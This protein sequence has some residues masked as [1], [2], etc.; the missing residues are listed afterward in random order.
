MNGE[1]SEVSKGPHSPCGHRN[2]PKARFCDVCGVKLPRHCPR[3]RA[4]NRGEANFCNNCGTGLRDSQRTPATPATA[5]FSAS[6]DSS[7]TPEPGS[8]PATLETPL[9]AQQAEHESMTRPP[10]FNAF[11]WVA[12]EQ[13]TTDEL[14]DTRERIGRFLERRRRGRRARVWLGTASA[15]I[16]IGV[17]GAT[18]F[19]GGVMSHPRPGGDRSAGAILAVPARTERANLVRTP[20]A[21]PSHAKNLPAV[22]SEN[23]EQ[24]WSVLKSDQRRAGAEQLPSSEVPPR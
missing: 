3:C 11:P 6:A 23:D 17:L 21:T 19:L 1:G 15:V 16:G 10:R 2:L 12:A 9:P 8:V 5:H 24:Q 22:L 20:I 14:E 18:P 4:V 7:P 13:L